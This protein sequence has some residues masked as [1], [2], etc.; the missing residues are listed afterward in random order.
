MEW[1]AFALQADTAELLGCCSYSSRPVADAEVSIALVSTIKGKTNQ[2][3]VVARDVK[4][5]HLLALPAFG[6]GDKLLITTTNGAVAMLTEEE[7]RV[8][9]Y[10]LHASL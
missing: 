2:E 10:C 7:L 8:R 1:C 5:S 4:Y 6:A 3:A 9:A